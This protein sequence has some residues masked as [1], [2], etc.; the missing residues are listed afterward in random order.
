M[1]SLSSS[2]HNFDL[3]KTDNPYQTCPHLPKR[4]AIRTVA[5]L[6]T[7]CRFSIGAN[8]TM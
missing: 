6:P 7:L 4:S 1:F 5:Y 2:F 3:F 8:T